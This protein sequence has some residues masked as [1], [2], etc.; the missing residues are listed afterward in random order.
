MGGVEENLA[1]ADCCDRVCRGRKLPHAQV[2]P[3]LKV[4]RFHLRNRI[5]ETRPR[6]RIRPAGHPETLS[7]T[8][9]WT[10]ELLA[11]LRP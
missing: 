5:A 1:F 3:A 9:W 11:L 8:K 4:K 10:A 7:S 6:P 2:S